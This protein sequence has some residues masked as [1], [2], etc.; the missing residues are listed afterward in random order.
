[1]LDGVTTDSGTSQI[2]ERSLMNAA[3]LY[4]SLVTDLLHNPMLLKTICTVEVSQSCMK[5]SSLFGTTTDKNL[6]PS[7]AYTT[8]MWKALEEKELAGIPDK[9]ANRIAA[10]AAV[11]PLLTFLFEGFGSRS[12]PF[13]MLPELVQNVFC[14]A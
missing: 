8:S 13:L 3:A 9:S 10:D 5:D 4:P 2:F 6:V 14:I 7:S 12:F 11:S 1:M